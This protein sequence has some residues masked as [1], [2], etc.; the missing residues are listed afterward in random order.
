MH[1][2][3]SVLGNETQALLWDFKIQ[4]DHLISARRPEL[5]IFKKKRGRGLTIIED[6]VDASL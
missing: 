5:I 3:E 6:S 1:N 4:R 2:T